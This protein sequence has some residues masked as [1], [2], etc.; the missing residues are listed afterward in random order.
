MNASTNTGDKKIT[1]RANAFGYMDE[2]K[3]LIESDGSVLVWDRIAG[4]YTRCHSLSKSA[5]S[6]LVKLSQKVAAG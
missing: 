3:F 1:A 5:R 2:H 6:R 4:H